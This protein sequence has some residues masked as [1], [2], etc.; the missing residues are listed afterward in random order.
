MH[1]LALMIQEFLRLAGYLKG[2]RLWMF[3][4]GMCDSMEMHVAK[5]TEDLKP[6]FEWELCWSNEL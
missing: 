1:R 6:A 3:P 5:Y 4:A 2:H